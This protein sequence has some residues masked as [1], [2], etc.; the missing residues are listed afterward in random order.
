MVFAPETLYSNTIKL[1]HHRI[2]FLLFFLFSFFF[3]PPSLDAAYLKA[4]QK[5]M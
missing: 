2:Y 4:L 1:T 5:Q 3:F